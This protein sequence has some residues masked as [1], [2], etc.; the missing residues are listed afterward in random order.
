MKS[1]ENKVVKSLKL[2]FIGNLLILLGLFAALDF[3]TPIIAFVALLSI[4][5]I[6]KECFSFVFEFLLKLV[7]LNFYKE[8][9]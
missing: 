7:Y 2:L 9:F 3:I 5:G 8:F 4:V 1:K 6:F